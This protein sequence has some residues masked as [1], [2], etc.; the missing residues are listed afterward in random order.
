MHHSDWNM[1]P[2]PEDHRGPERELL[3]QR[4]IIAPGSVADPRVIQAMREV[5]RHEF[6]PA[7]EMGAA[8]A[9]HPLPIG[10]GQTIS[11]PSLVAWMTQA[12]EPR[13]TDRI[14]EIGCGSGYQAA[15]LSRLVGEVYSIEIIPELAAMARDNLARVGVANV[16]IRT[17]DGY[18]GWPEAAPFDGIIV[19]CCPSDMPPP[20]IEQLREGGRVVIPVGDAADQTLLVLEKEGARLREV[21]TLPVRFVPMTGQAAA[22]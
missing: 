17:G 18:F 22:G 5:P 13:A 10:Y 16:H 15:I 14:L 6:V 19:T 20:L 9:N 11:Q 21:R 3:V 2:V 4:E 1:T 12:L 7:E 8:Y